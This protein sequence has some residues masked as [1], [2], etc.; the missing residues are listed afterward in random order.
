MK[1]L[2]KASSLVW[3]LLFCGAFANGII[4]EVLIKRWIEE[5]WA[6]HISAVTAILILSFIVFLMAK[7]LN[8]L[9]PQEA[10]GVGIYWF[11]LTV[12][13]ETF[14]LG[15]WLGNQSWDQILENY[16]LAKGNLWPLVLLW[17][18]LLPLIVFY[19]EKRRKRRL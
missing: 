17:I 6:H 7:R 2:F 13:A 12:L 15:R 11:V 14:L 18:G 1:N 4:R 16:N 5:P 10:I 3:L 8:I 9:R 19:L